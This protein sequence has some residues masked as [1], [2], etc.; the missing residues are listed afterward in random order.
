MVA[1]LKPNKSLEYISS[2]NVSTVL[3]GSELENISFFLLYPKSPV[4]I[5]E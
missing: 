2:E 4:V 5:P 3:K 1:A